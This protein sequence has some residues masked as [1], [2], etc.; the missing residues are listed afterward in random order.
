MSAG[1]DQFTF[2]DL[3][4]RAGLTQR[5]LAD[6]MGV[7]VK[8]VSAWERGVVDPRLTFAETQQLMEI[9]GCSFQDLVNATNQRNTNI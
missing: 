6:A 2:A 3:R 1:N 8:S 5:Q 9:L 4:K 7:T